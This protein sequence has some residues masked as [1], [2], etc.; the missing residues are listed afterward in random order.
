MAEAGTVFKI[1]FMPLKILTLAFCFQREVLKREVLKRKVL[2]LFSP[3]I[4]GCLT[5]ESRAAKI[6]DRRMLT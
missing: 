5:V 2:K 1:H 3:A 6:V 4:H